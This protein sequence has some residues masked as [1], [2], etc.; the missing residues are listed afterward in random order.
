MRWWAPEGDGELAGGR[1]LE[2]A[3]GIGEAAADQRANTTPDMERRL[4]PS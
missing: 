3:A 4:R 2:S 1:A